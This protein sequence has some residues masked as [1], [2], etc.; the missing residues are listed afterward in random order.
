MEVAGW[1]VAFRGSSAVATG[2][3]TRN[4][5]RGPGFRRVFTDTYVRSGDELT[6]ELRSLAAYRYAAG[7]GVMSGY[8]AAE[9]LGASCGDKEAPAEIT[10][11]GG[12]RRPQPGLLVHRDRIAPGEIQECRG[13][14][15]TIPM[16]TAW[17][18]ARRVDLDDAVAAVDTLARVGR[19][20]PD[21]LLNFLVHYPGARGAGAVADVLA[22]ADRR[23]G[24]PMETRLRLLLIHA[25]LPRPE[26][27]WVVQDPIAREAVWLDLAYPEHRVGI[28]YDGGEHLSPERVLSDIRRGTRLVDQGWRI[29]RYTKREIFTKREL[30]VSEVRRALTQPSAPPRWFDPVETTVAARSAAPGQPARTTLPSS[31]GDASSG[32]AGRTRTV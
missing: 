23:S 25:G 22:L 32:W 1:P 17:D 16:R 19:F 24:S 29:Y 8:S 3:V 20:H 27:Q 31:A 12:G 11:S 14:R 21:L 26:V 28:E 2:L 30:I 10:I 13:V 4:R 15:V 9:L 6:L 5:L 18:L 7:R